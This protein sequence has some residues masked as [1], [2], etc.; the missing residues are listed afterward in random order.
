MI[1]PIFAFVFSV[2]ISLAVGRQ[3]NS[4]V[5]CQDN[6][7]A[8]ERT[9]AG[10]S[11]TDRSAPQ[12]HYHTANHHDNHTNE[13]CCVVKNRVRE[14]HRGDSVTEMTLLPFLT[15]YLLNWLWLMLDWVLIV[16]FTHHSL[17]DKLF[18]SYI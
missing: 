5:Y 2:R 7:R 1:T 10:L 17:D 4:P 8:N 15:A 6:Q 16:A 9:K 14:K 13:R 12:V 3:V 18:L 11:W